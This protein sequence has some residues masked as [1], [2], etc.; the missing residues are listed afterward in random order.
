MLITINDCLINST[1]LYISFNNDNN[2]LYIDIFHKNDSI[3]LKEKLSDIKYI[4]TFLRNNDKLFQLENAIVQEISFTPQRL[5][6]IIEPQEE[7]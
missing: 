3:E 1:A 6:L 7:I 5:I 4:N 2:Y